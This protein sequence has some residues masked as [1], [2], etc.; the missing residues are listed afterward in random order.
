M[1]SFCGRLTDQEGKADILRGKVGFEVVSFKD[2]AIRVHKP[3]FVLYQVPGES[4]MGYQGK[5]FGYF[6]NRS[7]ELAC[8]TQ[9][10]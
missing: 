9:I 3:A 8:S 6:I 5:Y 1:H 7:Y 10:H 4:V 2:D